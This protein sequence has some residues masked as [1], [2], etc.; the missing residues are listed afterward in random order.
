MLSY[1]FKQKNTF[2]ALLTLLG[3]AIATPLMA[4][5]EAGVMVVHELQQQGVTLKGIVKDANGEPIIGASVVEKGEN[6]QRHNYGLERL[7]CVNGISRCLDSGF[8]CRIPHRG[9]ESYSP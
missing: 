7:F 1:L 4:S 8:I 6:N 3:S 9:V 2:A 5:S